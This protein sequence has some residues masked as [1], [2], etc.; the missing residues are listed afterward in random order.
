MSTNVDGITY[1]TYE[2]IFGDEPTNL[3]MEEK[4]A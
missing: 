4:T 3:D 2:D 1:P